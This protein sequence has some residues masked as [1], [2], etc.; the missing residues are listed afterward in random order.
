MDQV[1]IV[2]F[3]IAVVFITIV[4]TWHEYRLSRSISES[5]PHLFE[6]ILKQGMVSFLLSFRKLVY[7]LQHVQGFCGLCNDTTTLTIRALT[8]KI[9]LVLCFL[10][11]FSRWVLIIR[12]VS[13]H[14]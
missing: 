12:Y 5:G 7:D 1:L 14:T 2:L 13:P 3:D 4:H 6:I 11:L 8:C 9:F 10:I